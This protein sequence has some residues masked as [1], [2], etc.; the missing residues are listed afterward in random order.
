MTPIIFNRKF[1]YNSQKVI[2][3]EHVLFGTE[4][5]LYAANLPKD[6][7]IKITDKRVSEIRLIQELDL[8][9]IISGRGTWFSTIILRVDSSGRNSPDHKIFENLENQIKVVL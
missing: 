1:F 8:I 7:F 5:G 2:D 3:Y 4:E 9:F 6:E